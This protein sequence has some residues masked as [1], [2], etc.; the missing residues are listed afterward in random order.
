MTILVIITE[1]ITLTGL[2]VLSYKGKEFYCN[3]T[4]SGNSP[5]ILG[6]IFE[7]LINFNLSPVEYRA[8]AA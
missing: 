6:A 3:E 7:S 2:I 8:K 1:L 5:E 4:F